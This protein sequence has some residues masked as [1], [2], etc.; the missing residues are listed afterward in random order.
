MISG[1]ICSLQRIPEV[2][3]GS[4]RKYLEGWKLRLD[5][6]FLEASEGFE[7]WKAPLKGSGRL[8]PVLTGETAW[9]WD[10][11]DGRVTGFTGGGWQR[12]R[13]DV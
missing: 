8:P 2:K 10:Y 13:G 9:L 11:G 1:R 3:A 7:G 12:F 4:F 5:P 6:G